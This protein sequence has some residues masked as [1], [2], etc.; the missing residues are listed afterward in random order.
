ME[1]FGDRVAECAENVADLLGAAGP[2]A[3]ATQVE[4]LD[5]ADPSIRLRASKAILECL[6]VQGRG[7][8]TV[9]VTTNVITPELNDHLRAGVRDLFGIDIAVPDADEG[10]E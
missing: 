10:A 8:P 6:G 7:G 3:A 5:D 2:L 4:L 1:V 9:N